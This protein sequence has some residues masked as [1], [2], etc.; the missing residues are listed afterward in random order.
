VQGAF[1]YGPLADLF[2]G[3]KLPTEAEVPLERSKK[4]APLFDTSI[5]MLIKIMGASLDQFDKHRLGYSN[6]ELREIIQRRAEQEKQN[7]LS[8]LDKMP[9]EQRHV[10]T[11][12]MR[13]GLGRYNVDK[14]KSIIKY[15]ADQI[16]LERK[17]GIEAGITMS[18]SRAALRDDDMDVEGVVTEGGE[19]GIIDEDAR[20]RDEGYD[21]H[22]GGGDAAEFGNDEE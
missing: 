8:K 19:E 2:N 10:A 18:L 13:L 7:I 14:L 5:A 4:K 9:A 1:L 16:E 11:M 17:E 20:E 12:N 15:S 6:E 21:E 22:Q 3:S